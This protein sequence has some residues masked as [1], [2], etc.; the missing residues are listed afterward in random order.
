MPSLYICMSFFKIKNVCL[1]TMSSFYHM[2]YP[3]HFKFALEST[4]QIQFGKMGP[5]GGFPLF[6]LGLNVDSECYVH[7]NVV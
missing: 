3:V 6:I 4:D 5:H 7:R 1:G 2:L